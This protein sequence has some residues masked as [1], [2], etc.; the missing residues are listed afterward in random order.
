MLDGMSRVIVAD[1]REPTAGDEAGP[2]ANRRMAMESK[3]VVGA[4]RRMAMKM[5]PVVGAS[6]RGGRWRWR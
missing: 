1:R 6:R 5:R 2:D 3:P 4:K